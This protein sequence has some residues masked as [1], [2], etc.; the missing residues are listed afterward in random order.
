MRNGSLVFVEVNVALRERDR[1][2]F[3]VESLFNPFMHVP[4]HRPQIVGFCPGAHDEIDR[5]ITKGAN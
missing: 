1:N 5:V 3:L 4:V 2:A